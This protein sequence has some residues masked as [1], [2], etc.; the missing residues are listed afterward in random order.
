MKNN[1]GITLISLI[2]YVILSLMVISVLIAI[3]S[4]FK[5]NFNEL[6]VQ[7]VQDIELDKLNMQISKEIKDGK[8]L[9]KTKTTFTKLTFVDGNVYTY[10]Q[11]DKAIYMNDNV[12]VAE[13][14]GSCNFEV[15]Y[16][17]ILRVTVQVEGKTRVMEYSLSE[18]YVARI[19]KI[20]YKTLQSAIDAVPV[21]NT[22]TTIIV[23]ADITENVSIAQSQ[24]IVL[25]IGIY[26]INNK[27]DSSVIT[28]SGNL[29]LKNGT[30]AGNPTSEPLINN[31]PSGVLNVVGGTITSDSS[32]ALENY[33]IIEISGTAKIDG[34]QAIANKE[35]GRV[36]INGGIIKSANS[37]AIKNF[38]IVNISKTA[39]IEGTGSDNPT[40]YNETTATLT[41]TGG[42]ISAT[43]SNSIYNL[44][45]TTISET[46]NIIGNTYGI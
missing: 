20:Y 23:L 11:K 34:E 33:G 37:N 42:T 32:V 45:I 9:D 7:A 21:D 14:I 25:D 13:H 26:T 22:E 19:E 44:G 35:S 12:A 28:S 36:T 18:K 38:G 16:D 46:V 31:K 3:T 15:A 1:K 6:D 10:V 29:K 27:E 30:I 43:N 39:I 17:D 2:G 5:K 40:I 41:I 4:N 24:N 8:T